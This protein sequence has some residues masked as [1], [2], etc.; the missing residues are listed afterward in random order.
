[1]SWHLEIDKL[2]RREEMARRMGEP[3]KVKRQLGRKRTVR[4]RIERLMELGSFRKIGA[5]A[6]IPMRP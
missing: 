5:S 6:G 1:M 2:R 3:N 4:P